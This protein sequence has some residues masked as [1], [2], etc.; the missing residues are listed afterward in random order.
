MSYVPKFD[1]DT[2]SDSDKKKYD[3]MLEWASKKL[4]Y[5]V[6]DPGQVPSWL[7]KEWNKKQDE[8]DMNKIIMYA[9]IGVLIVI[10]LK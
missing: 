7:A 10:I 6:T 1:P 4:G 5:T 8:E 9:I 3:E 2:A